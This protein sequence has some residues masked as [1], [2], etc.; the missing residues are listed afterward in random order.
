MD[1]MKITSAFLTGVI[2]TMIRKTL[3]KKLGYNIDIKLN[4]VKIDIVDGKTH[5][6]IDMDCGVEKDEFVRILRGANLA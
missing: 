5:A 4:E 6:H 2:S 3:Q 1:E